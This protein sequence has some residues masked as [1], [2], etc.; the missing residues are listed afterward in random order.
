ML[1]VYSFYIIKDAIK[2]KQAFNDA[3]E[4]NKA[5]KAGGEL[6]YATVIDEDNSEPTK[7]VEK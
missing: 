3:R 5:V 6:K 2:F 4:F 1:K 7:E